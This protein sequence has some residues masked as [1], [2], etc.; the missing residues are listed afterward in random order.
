MA[1][2]CKG[3]DDED[4]EIDEDEVDTEAKWEDPSH[5]S[6]LFWRLKWGWLTPP[7]FMI[8]ALGNFIP[9]GIVIHYL[10]GVNYTFEENAP[11]IHLNLGPN[12]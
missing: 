6:Q 8:A 2:S 5:S 11:A 1:R 7:L 9:D 4:P 10:P 3:E 12:P